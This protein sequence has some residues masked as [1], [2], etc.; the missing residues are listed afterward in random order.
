M[1]GFGLGERGREKLIGGQMWQA[2]ADRKGESEKGLSDEQEL[3]KRRARARV[4][5]EKSESNTGLRLSA[6]Q[7]SFH[8]VFQRI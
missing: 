8:R 7:G 2:G 5:K 1:R 3:R 4:A 6:K